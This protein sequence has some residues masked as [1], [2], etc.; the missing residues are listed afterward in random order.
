MGFRT[1][2][3]VDAVADGHKNEK[4]VPNPTLVNAEATGPAKRRQ[5]R[6]WTIAHV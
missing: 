1:N 4:S 6:Q 5:L 3:N 2:C